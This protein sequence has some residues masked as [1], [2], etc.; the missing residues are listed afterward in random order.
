MV[1][2]LRITL[3]LKA[4]VL[5]HTPQARA[6]SATERLELRSGPPRDNKDPK[7]DPWCKKDPPQ[8]ARGPP[9][10]ENGP[11]R[12]GICPQV[13]RDSDESP[14]GMWGMQALPS[15]RAR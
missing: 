14:R 6:T 3:V 4:G 1:P 11:P 5:R 7:K 15:A 12:G 13:P 8:D 2:P 10:D 9:Q